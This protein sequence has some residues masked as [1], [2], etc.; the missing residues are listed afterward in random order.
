MISD[1]AQTLS[2]AISSGGLTE[3]CLHD[4]QL[5]SFATGLGSHH[6]I[7]IQSLPRARGGGGGLTFS[8]GLPRTIA[9]YKK[10]QPPS[11]RPDFALCMVE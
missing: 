1:Q 10:L 8:R 3:K 4:L 7:L 6:P 9:R 11:P 5:V 2:K